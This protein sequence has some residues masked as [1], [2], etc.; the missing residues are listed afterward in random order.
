MAIE[1]DLALL[2]TLRAL[3]ADLEVGGEREW[4]RL[5]REALAASVVSVEG[6]EGVRS[7]LRTLR[8][9]EAGSRPGRAER[10]G[11]A[12]GYFDQ[13]LGQEPQY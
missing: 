11:A 9:A 12:L 4:A 1:S 2:E 8:D 6:K 10:I 13:V 3:A 7:V 5:L